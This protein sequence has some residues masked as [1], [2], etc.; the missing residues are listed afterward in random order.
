MYIFIDK[1]R[2]CFVFYKL[3]LFL[4]YT[5]VQLL[6]PNQDNTILQVSKL[7]VLF[8]TQ[9]YIFVVAC[10]DSGKTPL[11]ST[12]SVYINVVDVNDNAP[13]FDPMSYSNELYENAT[14][15]TS[16]VTVT[17]TDLDSGMWSQQYSTN[18]FLHF[19]MHIM[20]FFV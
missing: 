17:A 7:I 19:G 10:Q 6:E 9:H 12:V 20:Y 13:L 5:V 18:L 2:I 3:L 16:V 1:M 4:V 8:Q 11:S 14:V 15:G